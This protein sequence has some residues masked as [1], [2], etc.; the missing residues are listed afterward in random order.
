MSYFEESRDLTY[1]RRGPRLEGR[2]APEG[3]SVTIAEPSS[4]PVFVTLDVKD[5][6]RVTSDAEDFVIELIS[7]GIREA[8]EGYTG[9]LLTQRQ[10]TAVW[11]R[12]WLRGKLPYPPVQSIASIERWDVT[13]EQYE[14]IAADDYQ[15]RENRLL[16]EDDNGGDALK[17]VYTAGYSSIPAALK[18]QALQ[19]IRRRYEYRDGRADGGTELPDP[20][21]YDRWRVI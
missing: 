4:T 3:L 5:F 21:L 2:F 16:I 6:L 1:G 7:E 8:V 14:T 10:V 20:T 12:F 9:R 19:D 18:L 11:D 17:V 15:L 13:D